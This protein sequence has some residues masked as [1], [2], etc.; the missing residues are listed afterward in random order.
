MVELNVPRARFSSPTKT[1]LFKIK[2][3]ITSRELAAYLSTR[4]H[5]R[6]AV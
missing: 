3:V 6:T 5:S 4:A 2:K 1:R